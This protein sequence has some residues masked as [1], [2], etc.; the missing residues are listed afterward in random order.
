MWDVRR[1]PPRLTRP[2][3]TLLV[4]DAERDRTA[5]DDPEL[6][7]LV[8]V[9]RDDA[10]RLE[11]DDCERH[12]IA[13]DRA[14]N[15]PVPDAERTKPGEVVEGAHGR[16]PNRGECAG[17]NGLAY[18]ERPSDG[19]AHALLVLH[20][21]RGADERDLLPLADALD[22]ARRL[23]VV[24][25]RAPLELPGFP[26]YHW[27]VVPRVGYPDPETF[28]GAFESLARF[29]DDLWARTGI[30]PERTVLGGF[31][32]GSVMSYALGLSGERPVP[33]GILAFSG[34]TPEVA[35]WQPALA[36]RRGLRVFIVHGRNDPVISVDFGR[37]ARELLAQGGLDVEYH[38]SDLAHQIDLSHVAAAADWLGTTLPLDETE[39]RGQ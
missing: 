39:L 35:G 1:D 34:F 4:T 8:G 3:L 33:A 20:H 9:P 36:G 5:E 25:P 22:P 2:Q 16:E 6:L 38:E 31:S 29:H 12:P 37:R 26:G 10:P 11:L 13:M 19:A 24:S 32:M 15:D 7:V 28:R 21:G 14:C 23:H 18:E 17:V 30:A 27:Y